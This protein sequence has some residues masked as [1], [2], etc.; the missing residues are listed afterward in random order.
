MDRCLQHSTIRAN[1]CFRP[2]S[3]SAPPAPSASPRVPGEETIEFRAGRLPLASTFSCYG[4]EPVKEWD[5]RAQKLGFLR[6]IEART[7]WGRDGG[8]I[9]ATAPFDRGFRLRFYAL[10]NC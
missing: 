5:R 6:K 4:K 1:S 3:T 9:A 7:D 8:H 10:P 2:V